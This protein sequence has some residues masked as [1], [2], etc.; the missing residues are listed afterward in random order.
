MKSRNVV[1][2]VNSVSE[3]HSTVSKVVEVL[4]L[5]SKEVVNLTV[6]NNDTNGYSRTEID[7]LLDNKIDVPAVEDW[8]NFELILTL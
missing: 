8:G 2:S 4:T 7:A 1:Y 5:Q 6:I 3:N